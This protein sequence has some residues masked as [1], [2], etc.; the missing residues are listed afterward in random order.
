VRAVRRVGRSRRIVAHRARGRASAS[1]HTVLAS[2]VLARAGRGVIGV[3]KDP[4]V[5]RLRSE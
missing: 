5:P 1:P 3:E 2:A 4:G